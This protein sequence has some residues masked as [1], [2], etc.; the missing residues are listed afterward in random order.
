MTNQDNVRYELNHEGRIVIGTTSLAA[1]KEKMLQDM[2]SQFGNSC[3]L[4][5]HDGALNTFEITYANGDKKNYNVFLGNIRNESRSPYEKKIQ[6]GGKNPK[7]Y[8]KSNTLILG[9]YVYNSDDR[10]DEAIVVSYPI[11]DNIN[12][13]SN[14]SLRGVFTNQILQQAKCKGFVVD[15]TRNLIAFRAEFIFYYLDRFYDLHYGDANEITVDTTVDTNNDSNENPSRNRI[16][17]GAP[18]TGKSH[19]LEDKRKV[20]LGNDGTFERVTFHPDYT[21]ANF[22]GCYKPVMVKTCTDIISDDIKKV[23]DILTDS[24]KSAQE[25]YD[26]L[27]DEFKD[28]NLTRLPL[29]LGLY[30]DETFKTKKKNETD[31]VNDNGV[32]R[33]HGR[34]IRPYIKLL[35]DTKAKEEIAYKYVPGP[36]MRVLANAMKY[37]NQNHLL[38]IEEIN[39]ANTAAVFGDVFQLLDRDETGCSKYE[40][41]TSEDMRKYLAEELG[42]AESDV[43]NTIEI[44]NNMYIWATMNS[45]DQGVYPMDTAFKRRWDFEYIGIDENEDKLTDRTFNVGENNAPIKWNNLRKAINEWLVNNRV[46]EDKLLGPFFIDKNILENANDEK[47]KEVFCNKVLMY[48]FEDAAR[49]KPEIFRKVGDKGIT[50]FDLKKRFQTEGIAIFNEKISGSIFVSANANNTNTTNNN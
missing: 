14:P 39:R 6:L 8:D 2:L 27:F 11:D 18:G 28:N 34:A 16:I 31:A 50:F 9:M 12:Y 44:P 30:T 48:L 33:N 19:L 45:A 43:K 37:T 1:E 5:D 49:T 10:F 47:F 17:F 15:E 42:V 35:S 24:T 29:L 7:L 21:Y 4:I 25:K 38:L 32:E 40:I 20:L 41:H 46:R 22:V 26:L 36:F 13:E 23:V 3:C